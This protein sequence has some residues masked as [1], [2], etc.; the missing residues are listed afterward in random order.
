[1]SPPA[2][3]LYAQ[4]VPAGLGNPHSTAD[5]LFWRG[6]GISRE[7]V[8]VLFNSTLTPPLR[9]GGGKGEGMTAPDAKGTAG[10]AGEMAGVR[11]DPHPLH[12]LSPQ[13]D[14]LPDYDCKRAGAN[15]SP[16][17]CRDLT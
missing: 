3:T 11:F 13:G 6:F 8:Q 2:F 12:T 15:G 16:G 7:L 1:M 17:K 10:R 5:I 9:Q 4:K 14:T